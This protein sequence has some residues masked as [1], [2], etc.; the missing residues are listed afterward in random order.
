MFVIANLKIYNNNFLE[1][2]DGRREEA[3]S[4]ATTVSR[5]RSLVLPASWLRPGRAGRRGW[6]SR[7]RGTVTAT[8]QH[9]ARRNK[10]VCLC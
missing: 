1:V 9:P 8:Q 10:K 5:R 4:R 2:S 6:S 3:E 7:V